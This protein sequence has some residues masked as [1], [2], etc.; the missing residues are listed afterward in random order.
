M[1]NLLI[2]LLVGLLMGYAGLSLAGDKQPHMRAA[3]MSLHAAQGQIQKATPDKG[4]HRTRALSLVNQ[5]IA[6]VE[7][8]IAFDN[9]HEKKDPR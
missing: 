8:G 5:A 2:G 3:L 7:K 1:K 9:K 4:G 6:E